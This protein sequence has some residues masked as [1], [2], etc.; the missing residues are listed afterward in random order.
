MLLK[1]KPNP[2]L[3]A[4]SN[5]ANRRGREL[6]E[7]LYGKGVMLDLAMMQNKANCRVHP[8]MTGWGLHWGRERGI[9]MGL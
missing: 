1:T 3:P 7:L 2:G 8:V 5:K 4:V 6:T 9:I